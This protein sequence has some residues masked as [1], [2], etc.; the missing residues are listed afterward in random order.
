[1][2]ARD[3]RRQFLFGFKESAGQFYFQQTVL[4]HYEWVCLEL[5][6]GII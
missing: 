6:V 1:V 5:N 3:K 4:Y 2:F